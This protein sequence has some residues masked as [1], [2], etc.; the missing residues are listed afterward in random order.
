M[1]TFDSSQS[2]DSNAS[3]TKLLRSFQATSR[4]SSTKGSKVSTPAKIYVTV[5]RVADKGS[6]IENEDDFVVEKVL[7]E[8]VDVGEPHYRTRFRSGYEDNVSVTAF[9]AVLRK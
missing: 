3:E 4:A 6:Y 1:A 9:K 2:S 5:P 8:N 7:G